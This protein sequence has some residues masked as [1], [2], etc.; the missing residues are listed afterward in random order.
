MVAAA[1][2]TSAEQRTTN[3]IDWVHN[4]VSNFGERNF[5]SL[6]RFSKSVRSI[7][8]SVT[9]LMTFGFV[10]VD[11]TSAFH[12]FF[13]HADAT[14]KSISIGANPQRSSV[15]PDFVV[16]VSLLEP[17]RQFNCSR[18][19]GQWSMVIGH[20]S[21]IGILRGVGSS[22]PGYSSGACRGPISPSGPELRLVRED[23][24]RV[25]IG[26]LRGIRGGGPGPYMGLYYPR[27]AFPPGSIKRGPYWMSSGGHPWRGAGPYTRLYCTRSAFPPGSI[28][29]SEKCFTARQMPRP[30]P[31]PPKHP[32]ASARKCPPPRN[33]TTQCTEI[34]RTEVP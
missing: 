6:W 30:A 34:P 18:V 1:E 9:R 3:L 33:T 17:C 31:Q 20:R 5:Q 7:C 8:F 24:E 29:S 14:G 11:A 16:R 22:G 23:R 13:L 25:H 21:V 32:K 12:A 27:S 15:A 19:I 28:K 26:C 2:R 4:S 10:P